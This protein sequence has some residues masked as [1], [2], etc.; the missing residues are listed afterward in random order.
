MLIFLI[1]LGVWFL[2]LSWGNAKSKGHYSASQVLYLQD[3]AGDPSPELLSSSLWW[4]HVISGAGILEKNGDGKVFLKS[5]NG[6]LRIPLVSS[7]SKKLKKE[8]FYKPILIYG[9]ISPRYPRIGQNHIT[10]LVHAFLLKPEVK[11]NPW[12]IRRDWSLEPVKYCL[13]VK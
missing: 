5:Y 7:L 3:L 4:P 11:A 2:S 13:T 10:G 6:N 9:V 8:C 12:I 1:S